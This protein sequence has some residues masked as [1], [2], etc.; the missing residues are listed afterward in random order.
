[1]RDHFPGRK[2]QGSLANWK[3]PQS[4]L[5]SV[6]VNKD[7]RAIR[8]ECAER[9]A[10]SE[11][12]GQTNRGQVMLDQ[13]EI[14]TA[15]QATVQ[16]QLQ[17]VH[18]MEAIGQMAGGIAH[19]VNNLL[20]VVNGIVDQLR[21]E[22]RTEKSGR[23]LDMIKTAARRGENLTRQ[24]LSFSQARAVKPRVIQLGQWADDMAEILRNSMRRDIEIT[25]MT[26][27][28]ACA[29]EVDPDDLDLA[30]LNLAVNARDAMPRGGT[31]TI[32]ITPV[33]LDAEDGCLSVRDEFVAISLADT[34]IGIP[35][36]NLSHVFEPY[37]T[38][39]KKGKGTGL[40]LSQVYG[41]AKQAAGHVTISSTVGEGT[42]VTIYLPRSRKVA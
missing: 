35:A 20:M 36:A 30:V 26:P 29:V 17:N 19:D 4:E 40:G 38:T 21:C 34:G 12:P 27:T 11:D 14:E 37:F 42:T 22:L 5:T 18:K 7:N 16:Q 24:L 25:L 15:L 9:P 41:F 31:F 33:A 6:P 1:M 39:K 28:A 8:A 23:L 13:I 2:Q 10:R 3:E 32:A